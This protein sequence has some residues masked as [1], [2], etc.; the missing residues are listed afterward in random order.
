MEKPTPDKLKVLWQKGR[1]YFSTFFV[2]LADVRK[3]IGNDRDFAFWC[4]NDLHIGLDALTNVSSI[5]KKTDASFVKRDLAAA[6]E[7]ER[8]RK[9]VER[10]AREKAA[11]EERA[12]K[13][14]EKEQ[15][16]AQDKKER[17][18]K[19]DKE[20]Y[21]RKKQ[22]QLEA[23]AKG[24]VKPN[25]SLPLDKLA[26]PIKEAMSRLTS[27]RGEWINA[28]IDLASLLCQARGKIT[29]DPLFGQWLQDNDIDLGSHDRVAL[30]SLGTNL[31]A[32]RRVLEETERSSYRLIWKEVQLTLP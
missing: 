32:M 20:Y 4:I 31:I 19:H 30:L 14:L 5:L 23:Y 7:A 10:A 1:N 22:K 8:A 28:S 17:K 27:A 25:G 15:K 21:R 26:G 2:E 16:K 12:K 24:G 13:A 9:S 6:R 11:A 3:A 29:S 18:K